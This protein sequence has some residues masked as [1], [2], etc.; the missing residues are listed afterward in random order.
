MN[1]SAIEQALKILKDGGVVVYPTDTAY[2]LAVDAT[3]LTAVKK[4]YALK[5]RE[6][7][8]PIHIIFPSVD[9]LKKNVKLDKASLKLMNRFLPG[10][11]T[12]VA[13]L[14]SRNRGLNKIKGTTGIGLRLPDNS[15]AQ[16]LC[17]AFGKPITTTSANLSGLPSTYSIAAVKK[18]FAK[19]KLKP[20]F[21][22][23]G[24]R[25][26][27]IKPS[28]IVSVVNNNV[29]ILREGP[30]SEKEIKKAVNSKE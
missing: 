15:T 23:D 2:G 18:Q 5:G 10:P 3:N 6:F 9:W 22:L 8:K 26:K 30:I 11:L 20:D 16:A 25:L 29:T 12:I 7:N 14:K 17:E 1:Q 27:K 21:Y 28:T 19:S 13:K 24:G 4:L